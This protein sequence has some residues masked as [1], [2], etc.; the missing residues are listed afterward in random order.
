M[1]DKK[2]F[3]ALIANEAIKNLCGKDIL[4]S[5]ISH[6]YIIDGPDGSGKHTAAKQIAM[7]ILCENKGK[8]SAPCPCGVCPS[9]KK[10]AAGF[11]TCI[12]YVNRGSAATLQVETIRKMLSAVSYLP[13]DGDHKIYIIE[14]AHKMTTAAQNALLLT[15]E[16]PPSHAVFILLTSDSGALLETVRSRALVLKTE[17]LSVHSILSA[18]T[19]MVDMGKIPDVGTEKMKTAASASSGCLGRAVEF[20]TASEDSGSMKLRSIGEKLTDTLLFASAAEAIMYCR[21][22]DLKRPEYETVFY[23]AMAFLRDYIA[24]KSGADE[25]I[26]SIDTD[27]CKQTAERLALP[28]LYRTYELLRAAEEDI[29]KRNASPLVVL[30]TLAANAT[31]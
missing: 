22:V 12:E 9:C 29:T 8:S 20:C 3:P 19:S 7:A 14:D 15:L 24:V 30:C 27:K 25:T 31:K 13:E 17:L 26:V 21:S 1:N 5:H 18:L 23:Y 28:R 4:R 11:S 10:A 16:E 2:I 6:A